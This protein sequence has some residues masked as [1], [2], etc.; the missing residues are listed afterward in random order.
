MWLTTARVSV[1]SFGGD[2][3]TSAE[4]RL[5]LPGSLG[6]NASDWTADIGDAAG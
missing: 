3:P 6:W 1:V 5:W 2:A 4:I